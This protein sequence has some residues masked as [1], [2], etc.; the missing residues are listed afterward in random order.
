ML[1]AI[2][3]IIVLVVGMVLKRSPEP[4]NRFGRLVSVIGIAVVTLTVNWILLSQFT[5]AL[6]R[7]IA[8]LVIACP[9]AMGLATPAAIAVGLG[10]AAKNGILFRN[11][12]SLELFKNIATVVFDKTGTLTKGNFKI[13]GFKSL[14]LPTEEFKQV[15]F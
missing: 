6:M 3:G 5:P 2:L 1:I 14:S 11:A 9:C 10:R 8:V 4:G 7:S 15:I 12:K 13:T